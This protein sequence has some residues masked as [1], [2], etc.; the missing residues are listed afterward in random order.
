M[1]HDLSIIFQSGVCNPLYWLCSFAAVPVAQQTARTAA[2]AAVASACCLQNRCSPFLG[3][4]G[5]KQGQHQQKNRCRVIGV[6]KQLLVLAH[7]VTRI[8]VQVKQ[9]AA[10]NVVNTS[11]ICV[12]CETGCSCLLCLL[13]LSHVGCH[14]LRVS[15]EGLQLPRLHR[16]VCMFLPSSQ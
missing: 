3:V 6:A 4:L 10:T 2:T 12:S 15:P 11:V 7:A 16:Q 13:V 1:L 8:A 9:L 14:A 5:G